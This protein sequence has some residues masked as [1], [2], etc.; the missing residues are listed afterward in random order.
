MIV[1]GLAIEKVSGSQTSVFVGSFGAEYNSLLS[2]D[3]LHEVK[4]RATG[5]AVSMASNRLSW[6]YNLYGSS[7]TVD[8]A[9]SSSL[10]ALHLACEDLLKNNSEMVCSSIDIVSKNVKL[11]W[12]E[13]CRRM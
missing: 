6:F 8:T 10:T 13:R 2:R 12:L 4:Y 9:C 3:P 11:I 1:A 5:T 7:V